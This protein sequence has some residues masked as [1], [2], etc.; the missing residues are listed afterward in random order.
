MLA[1][2]LGRFRD[3]EVCSVVFRSGAALDMT[4]CREKKS[5]SRSSEFLKGR[6]RPYAS[7]IALFF[8]MAGVFAVPRNQAALYYL[9]NSGNDSADGL[10]EQT[11]W[12]TLARASS[13]RL[14]PGDNVL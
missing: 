12:K 14:S 7:R 8:L 9:D 10:S 4:F 1:I 5:I 3:V 11:A 13:A 6:C 2:R